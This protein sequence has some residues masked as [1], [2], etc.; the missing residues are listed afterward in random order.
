MRKWK[1]FVGAAILAAGLLLKAG[2]P[3]FAVVLGLALAGFLTWKKTEPS[4]HAPR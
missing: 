1:F 4:G 3:V 2:A